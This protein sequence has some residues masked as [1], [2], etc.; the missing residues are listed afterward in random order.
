MFHH[1][2]AEQFI[3][4]RPDGLVI[5]HIDR[6]KLNNNICN[7]RYVSQ[8]INMRNTD[9]YL[10]H[11][12]ETDPKKRAIIRAKEYAENN[13]EI[14]LKNKKKYYQENK[15]KF[16]AHNLEKINYECEI[17]KKIFEI[18]KKSFNAKKTKM[19]VACSSKNNLLLIK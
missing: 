4:K 6:D 3:G 18:K 12:Q 19:C 1:L 5:D 8:N 14:V 13:R 15:E 9:K 7:L 17:C 16:K 11:I 10:E 2:V